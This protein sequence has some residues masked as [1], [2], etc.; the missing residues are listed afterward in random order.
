MD[1]QITPGRKNGH[2]LVY[3]VVSPWLGFPWGALGQPWAALGRPW[4]PLWAT[5]ASYRPPEAQTYCFTYIKPLVGTLHSI[6]S[7]Q[8]ILPIRRIWCHQGQVRP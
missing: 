6:H 1:A 3:I 2:E 8:A 4:A 7:I 5:W